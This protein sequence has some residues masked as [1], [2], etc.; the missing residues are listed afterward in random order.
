MQSLHQTI[1]VETLHL[2]Y[3]FRSLLSSRR[4]FRLTDM[5]DALTLH[6]HHSSLPALKVGLIADE[7]GNEH[8]GIHFADLDAAEAAR[9]ACRDVLGGVGR[10]VFVVGQ[11]GSRCVRVEVEEVAALVANEVVGR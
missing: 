8:G 7:K 11:R 10:W 5:H 6:T 4:R 2:V 9:V 3:R 1:L